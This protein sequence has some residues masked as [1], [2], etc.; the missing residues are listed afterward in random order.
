MQSNIYSFL[1]F[2]SLLI[3]GSSCREKDVIGMISVVASD[4]EFG[5][6]VALL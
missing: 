4:R 6:E 2:P 3:V 5:M 1:D